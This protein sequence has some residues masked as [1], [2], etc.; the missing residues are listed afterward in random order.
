MPVNV[1][2]DY[3]KII[4]NRPN[5]RRERTPEQNQADRLMFAY[6]EFMESMFGGPRTQTLDAQEFEARMAYSIHPL[7][8]TPV[9]RWMAGLRRTH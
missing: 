6:R 7:T 2:R 5:E 4:T 3:M 1:G 8:E 9:D